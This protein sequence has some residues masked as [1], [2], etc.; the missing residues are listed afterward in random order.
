VSGQRGNPVLLSRELEGLIKGLSG[1]A[2]AGQILRGRADVMEYPVDD[3][4]ILQDVDTG[5]DL[6]R[7]SPSV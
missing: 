2:G 3:P 4:A 6:D 7:I 5:Y 1:D